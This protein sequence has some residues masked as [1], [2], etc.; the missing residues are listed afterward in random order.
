MNQI[1][2]SNQN[3]INYKNI[4]CPEC[5]ENAQIKIEDFKINL[6]GCKNG[7]NIKNISLENFEKT[8]ELNNS[9]IICDQC[10]K[11]NKSN[12]NEFFYCSTCKMNV[13]SSC[14]INH[15]KN[16]DIIDYEKKKNI[17][18]IHNEKYIK[19]CNE[20]QLNICM[21]CENSHKNHDLKYF[22]DLIP[23]INKI[24]NI[25]KRYYLFY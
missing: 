10:K 25:M 15:D 11:N 5:G 8:Q 24:N 1:N 17:C 23:D 2:H 12:N 7:H 16:H 6:F 21:F 18:D 20:C 3:S 19:H 14:K 4:I 9:K 22:G 13:C